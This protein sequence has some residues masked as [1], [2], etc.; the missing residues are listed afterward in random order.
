MRII[1]N[2]TDDHTDT[3]EM[4]SPPRVGDGV[5][6]GGDQKDYI[7]ANVDHVYQRDQYGR[8]THVAAHIILKEI[9]QGGTPLTDPR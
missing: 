2:Y 3:V 8:V 1:L 5:Q 4:D 9:P 6:I 7:V